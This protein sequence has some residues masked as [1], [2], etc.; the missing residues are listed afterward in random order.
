MKRLLLTLLATLPL[1]ALAGDYPVTVRSCDRDVTFE[2]APQRAVSHDV[3]LTGMLLALGLREHMVGYSGISGWKSL[4]PSMHQALSGLP[5]LAPRYPSVENLLDANVDFLFA[6]WSYGMQVGGPVTPQRLAPFGIPVYELSES[7]SR[8]MPRPPASL[9]DLYTD[10][11]NLGRIFAV[12][13][14]AE[15]LIDQLRQRVA[16]VTTSLAGAHARPRVFLYDSG[17]DRPTTS[18]RLGMPQALITTAG[19]D[20]VMADVRASWTEVSWES[21]V[22]RDPEVIVIVDYGPTSWQ[23]KRDFLLQHPALGDVT[24]IRERRFVV[25]SYLQVTPSVDNAA[26]IERLA[27]ALH[28]RLFAGAQQ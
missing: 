28:P 11:A 21:V 13:P 25:L 26:A 17:E 10:L 9:D 23:H 2:H 12:T 20:N 3:N 1:R 24:A 19:G 14:R 18:G 16:R 22:E 15:A 27:S 7:C 4:D 6:G 5:E 8:I